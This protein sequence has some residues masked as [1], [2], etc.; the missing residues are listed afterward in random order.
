MVGNL[1]SSAGNVAGVKFDLTRTGQTIAG[2]FIEQVFRAFPDY[3]TVSYNQLT[4]SNAT[5]GELTQGNATVGEL[6]QAMV[7][8]VFELD[9]INDTARLDALE[10]SIANNVIATVIIPVA[11][12]DRE[13][14]TI[15]NASGNSFGI[16]N[17]LF[18]LSD[19]P[20]IVGTLA[21]TGVLL[22][23]DIPKD[24]YLVGPS[25]EGLPGDG[26]LQHNGTVTG[27]H[28]TA[29]YDGTNV[30]Y[31]VV[32]SV[33]HHPG[34]SDYDTR[35]YESVA[36]QQ[37]IA[38]SLLS[39][40]FDL[41]FGPFRS[42]SEIDVNR[43][44]YTLV[45][46][47]ANG[48]AAGD[49][50]F[51]FGDGKQTHYSRLVV[52]NGDNTYTVSTQLHPV[53]VI[54]DTKTSF[55]IAVTRIS[56]IK[57]TGAAAG[58]RLECSTDGVFGGAVPDVPATA[59]IPPNTTVT[60]EV[61]S[62]SSGGSQFLTTGASIDFIEEIHRELSDDCFTYDGGNSGQV[63]NGAFVNSPAF[64]VPKTG[65]Y[66]V[67]LYGS[68][69][70]ENAWIRL[71]TS[72]GGLDI[73]DGASD[74][75]TPTAP[76]TVYQIQLDAG[77]DIFPQLGV[78]GGGSAS[79]MQFTIVCESHPLRQQFDDWN[80]LHSSVSPVFYG[81]QNGNLYAQMIDVGA[82][83]Q[84]FRSG[85]DNIPVP[86][87]NESA[88]VTFRYY[89]D[90]SNTD[91]GM[92]RLI[93]TPGNA[94]DFLFSYV[95]KNLVDFR[96]VGTGI[97]PEL[98]E[99]KE[100]ADTIQHTVRFFSDAQSVDWGL[101][102]GV[103]ANLTGGTHSGFSG[104]L[105]LAE[106]ITFNGL[107]PQSN[108]PIIV[109]GL[110]GVYRISEHKD[111]VAIA[112]NA[113]TPIVTG[114]NLNQY[115]DAYLEFE[116]VDAATGRPWQSGKVRVATLLDKF[117]GAA[118]A[119]DTFINIFDNDFVALNLIDPMTGE[120]EFT[121]N[122]RDMSYR[123]SE[124]YITADM[125]ST[126]VGEFAFAATSARRTIATGWLAVNP[127]TIANGATDY[128]IWAAENP[129]YVSGSD[130]V[131]PANVEGIFLRNLGGNA[132]NEG[133][134]QA[135]QQARNPGNPIGTTV[136]SGG[137]N[138]VRSVTTTSETRPDNRAY[139][140]YTIVDNYKG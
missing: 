59:L 97:A 16:S 24:L 120:I 74:R 80:V 70:V 34:T 33:R 52:D 112:I 135:D 89:K 130:I 69:I 104:V 117:N 84:G 79:N 23:Q 101:Y 114:H 3:T 40:N 121:D 87:P 57:E 30:N 109:N 55:N 77:I 99:S 124:L 78:G 123:S 129:T 46:T 67:Y 85:V 110:T 76:Q 47:S 37:T 127:G 54:A 91:A 98:I 53:R 9:C 103:A 115:P 113:A 119:I 81:F 122:G 39:T 111:P 92:F 6:T 105:R 64:R 22:I 107:L 63:T 49:D 132:A 83:F 25:T 56:Y 15:T 139:Q 126:R 51:P 72:A 90:P 7:D 5:V 75:I 20:T 140:L 66:S 82:V 93:G 45:A 68:D 10:K 108:P 26:D 118:D 27:V 62:V 31:N 106:P 96:T 133:V 18:H 14:I 50:I 1:V 137:G 38:L 86:A 61:R 32:E 95:D 71:G 11:E 19:D 88:V 35:S 100:D 125:V 94:G 17:Y 12:T 13:H 42:S 65:L 4:D 134:F 48:Q 73:F 28:F 60:I 8:Y 41:L 2:T 116:F 138:T 102:P 136:N 21:G 58:T 29:T 131:F 36:A 43:A 128:P 44:R